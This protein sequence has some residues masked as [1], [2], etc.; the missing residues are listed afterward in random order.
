MQIAAKKAEQLKTYDPQSGLF[1]VDEQ[2]ARDLKREHYAAERA[3]KKQREQEDR[4]HM[5]ENRSIVGNS[6]NSNSTSAPTVGPPSSLQKS[7]K[8]SNRA[9]PARPGKPKAAKSTS[10][11]RPAQSSRRVVGFNPNPVSGGSGPGYGPSGLGR[12][13]G[14][15]EVPGYMKKLASFMA[16]PDVR[17]IPP[18]SVNTDSY[19]HVP[20]GNMGNMGNMS[21]MPVMN[22]PAMRQNLGL[23]NVLQAPKSNSGSGDFNAISFNA[24]AGAGSMRAPY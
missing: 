15:Q 12:Y 22:M 21:N 4:A 7:S 8:S 6:N 18:P 1:G 13:Q 3:Y 9:D 17:N 10:S 16:P 19:I 24:G 5:L 2:R 20:M 14:P 23:I 11:Q